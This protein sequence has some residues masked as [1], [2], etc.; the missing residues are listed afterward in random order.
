MSEG[1]GK[2]FFQG[3]RI[4]WLSSKKD[5]HTLKFLGSEKDNLQGAD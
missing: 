3:T 1:S 5:I 4:A 2:E